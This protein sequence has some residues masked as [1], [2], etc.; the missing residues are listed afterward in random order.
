M[1]EYPIVHAYLDARAQSIYAGTKEI[2]GRSI[3]V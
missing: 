1:L 2:I 3:G